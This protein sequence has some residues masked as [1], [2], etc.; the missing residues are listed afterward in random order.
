MYC[1]ECGFQLSEGTKYCPN[2]G[3]KVELSGMGNIEQNAVW[4]RIDDEDTAGDSNSVAKKAH[5]EN[6]HG[7]TEERRT[8]QMV[9]TSEVFKI[10]RK[11]IIQSKRVRNAFCGNFSYMDDIFISYYTYEDDTSFELPPKWYSD[12]DGNRISDDYD[13]VSPIIINKTATV[14]KREGKYACGKFVEEGLMVV[15]RFVFCASGGFG[16]YDLNSIFFS[17]R[18]SYC[19]PISEYGQEY[20][21]IIVSHLYNDEGLFVAYKSREPYLKGWVA[22]IVQVCFFLGATFCWMLIHVYDI[23]DYDS[24][25]VFWQKVVFVILYFFYIGVGTLGLFLTD[26]IFTYDVYIA[27][28]KEDSKRYYE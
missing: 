23:I 2:C 20:G 14:V 22:K 19:L 21:H 18:S 4:G 7:G 9:T 25:S 3:T 11:K 13:D 5:W 16:N 12:A 1:K 26:C 8:E 15:T 28:Y 6:A 10:K 17:N 27:M 24:M